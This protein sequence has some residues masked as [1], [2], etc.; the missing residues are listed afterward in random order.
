MNESELYKD[1]E[2]TFFMVWSPQGGEPSRKHDTLREA[3]S[4]A[5]R[6]ARLHPDQ[7]FIILE[8]LERRRTTNPILVVEHESPIPF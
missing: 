3:R 5:N 1:R 8:S 6:L 7:D 4:E 2:R